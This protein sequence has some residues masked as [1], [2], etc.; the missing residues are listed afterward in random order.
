MRISA[1]VFD[2]QDGPF[3]IEDVEIDDQSPDEVLVKISATGVCHTDG[4]AR[5]GDLPFPSPGVLGHE[6]A[7]VVAAVGAG[8]TSVREGDHVVLGWPWCGQ[9]CNCQSGEPRY[10]ARL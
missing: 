9:C 8:V 2:V 7:G 3:H 5:H 4:L 1:A 10:C 6:G